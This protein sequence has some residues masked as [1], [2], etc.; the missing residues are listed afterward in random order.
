MKWANHYL[1]VSALRDSSLLIH[2]CGLSETLVEALEDIWLF[3]EGC[4]LARELATL[5]G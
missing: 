5:P 1:L 4:D 2:H 3:A